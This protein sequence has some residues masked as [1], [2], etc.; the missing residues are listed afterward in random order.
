M[1][2]QTVPILRKGLYER[3]EPKVLFL[4]KCERVETG[5]E[6]TEEKSTYEEMERYFTVSKSFKSNFVRRM[7]RVEREAC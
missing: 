4:E 5:Q 1:L 6:V 7:E 2:S 3:R